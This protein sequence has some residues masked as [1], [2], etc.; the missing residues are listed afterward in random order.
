MGRSV[1]LETRMRAVLAADLEGVGVS[2]LCRQ[3]GISRDTFYRYRARFLAEGPAGLAARSRRPHRSP[4][5]ISAEIEDEV[6]SWRKRLKDLGVDHGAQTIFYHLRR[7]GGVPLPSVATIHRVLVRRGMVVPQPEKRPRASWRRF[8]WPR[9]NDAWQ[10]DAT[11]WVLADGRQVWIMDLIDDHS[12]LVT[13]ASVFA[14]ATVSAAWETFT[15]ATSRYRLP[16]HVMSDNGI[17]FTA[18]F[19]PGGENDFE[20]GLRALGIRQILSTPGHPQTCGKLERFHQTLKLWLTR[21]PA[22]PTLGHLQ[23]QLDGFL[24]YYNH[25]RPHRALGGDT[26]IQRWQATPPAQQAAPIPLPPQATLH[27]VD[28]TGTCSWKRH[29]IGIG[30]QHQGQTV[31]ICARGD[32]LT[33]FGATGL[34]R[35]LTLDH[36]R[37]YQPTGKPRGRRRT[38]G[39]RP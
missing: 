18:R 5:Q 23:T 15:T 22:A 14:G 20:S 27:Q 37:R 31:L 39:P 25:D 34:I 29:T 38:I 30:Q 28:H 8:E 4:N 21:Q 35:T 11:A 33:I 19:M 3:L 2:E 6:V 1:N 13:A 12:R 17:C 26:P 32:Q 10:I 16:A 36:S 7:Q 9:P 24:A